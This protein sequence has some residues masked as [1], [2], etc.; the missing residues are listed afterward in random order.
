[1]VMP[2]I[3][4]I[5]GQ[6]LGTKL[7]ISR[8][9]TRREILLADG[10]DTYEYSAPILIAVGSPVTWVDISAEF[11]Q[12][13]IFFPLDSVEFV[14]NSAQPIRFYRNA[15]NI[16]EIVPSYM[17]RPMNEVINQFGIANVGAA[18]TVAGEIL[19]RLRRLPPDVQRVVSAQ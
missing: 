12:A 14:N 17:V 5:A 13:R 9:P 6:I 1:M 18:D 19:I 7:N 15:P 2:F 8:A 4:G 10:S 11:P 3:T 16:S